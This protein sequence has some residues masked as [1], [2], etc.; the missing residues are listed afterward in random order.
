MS[1]QVRHYAVKQDPSVDGCEAAGHSV[2]DPIL[3]QRLSDVSSGKIS[4]F[5]QLAQGNKRLGSRIS[6]QLISELCG[7]RQ[8]HSWFHP[9]TQTFTPVIA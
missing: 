9:H 1:Q 7:K 5:K 6:L 4:K 8:S 3:F 2:L